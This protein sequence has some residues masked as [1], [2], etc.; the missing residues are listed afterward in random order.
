MKAD[1]RPSTR[2]L[3]ACAVDAARFAGNHALKNLHR[4]HQVARQFRHDVKLQLDLECQKKAESVIRR[5]FPAHAILG[6]E[7]ENVDQASG[8][9]LHDRLEWVIDPIDGTVNFSHGLPLWCCS[10][11]VRDGATVLAG[12]V[13]APALGELYT[14]RCDGPALRNGRPIRVSTV[15]TLAGSVVF[16]G[17]DKNVPRGVK[18][19]AAFEGISERIQRARIMGVA[20]L[21]MCR[22]AAGEAEGYFESG[23]YIWDVAAAGLIVQRAGGQATTLWRETGY[24]MAY[25]ATNGRIHAAF[26]RLLKSITRAPR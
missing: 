20:A 19:F 7:N 5:R 14:A 23:I 9:T 12:A 22:V 13:F 25:A 2:A 18:P 16:T 4:R 17:L 11:A 21:D 24:R 8:E 1:T 26:L 15:A 3:L 6:E 10:V